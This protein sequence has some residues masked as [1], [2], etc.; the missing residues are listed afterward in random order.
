M[1]TSFGLTDLFYIIGGMLLFGLAI[2]TVGALYS[3]A[4][5]II[6][7]VQALQARYLTRAALDSLI[8]RI[9]DL[10]KV[11]EIV[12]NN[13]EMPKLKPVIMS[14]KPTDTKVTEPVPITDTTSPVS[15]VPVNVDE[16]ITAITE[17]NLNSEQLEKIL[18]LL[19]KPNGDWAVSLN[20]VYD[21]VGGH[22]KTTQDRVKLTRETYSKSTEPITSKTPIAHRPTNA[23]FAKQPEPNRI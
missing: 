16:L 13:D 17:H 20:G 19:R 10:P 3:M 18:T 14:I 8:E 9:A 23:V 6:K 15:A 5:N 7:L 12:K 2:V 1:E 21:A 4:P 22:R 11:P